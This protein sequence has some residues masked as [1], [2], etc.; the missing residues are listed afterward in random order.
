MP[1]CETQTMLGQARRYFTQMAE[2]F[3]S[4]LILTEPDV[5]S[6]LNGSGDPQALSA[7]CESIRTC[8]KC[9]LAKSRTR[10]VFGTGNPRARLMLVGEAPGEEEDLRGEPFVGKAGQLLDKILGAIG[11]S[12]DEVFIANILK[13]R[14]PKNRDPEQEEIQT[15]LPHLEKQIALIQPDI[16]VALGRIA[17]QTLLGS[18]DPLTELR[19]RVH[20][21]AERPLLVTYH[22]AALLRNPEWKRPT[23]EDV[24]K[25]RKLYDEL[26]GDK[27]G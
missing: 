5:L 13:C 27:P 2:L 20:R 18:T 25:L 14:P 26:V 6:R 17:A 4:D 10:F 9:H 23:W 8:R 11:F 16:I 1:S 22:P 3:G 7:F 21:Y 19:S 24:Q 15:C 12:R